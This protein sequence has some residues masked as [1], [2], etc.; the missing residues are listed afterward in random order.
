M[1]I[2]SHRRV[3]IHRTFMLSSEHVAH[4]N[5]SRKK[6]GTGPKTLAKTL[7]NWSA[8][9][10][11][12]H[13]M[14]CLARH[15]ERRAK[16]CFEAV[17]AKEP[18]VGAMLALG[19]LL[20]RSDSLEDLK[21]ALCYAQRAHSLAD[22]YRKPEAK[23]LLLES[24]KLVAEN[25]LSLADDPIGGWEKALP[26]LNRIKKLDRDLHTFKYGQAL[27]TLGYLYH[28]RG[29]Q[30]HSYQDLVHAQDYFRQAKALSSSRTLDSWLAEIDDELM[31]L[32][33]A[34]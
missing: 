5:Q 33:H 18:H 14:N 21:Q 16:Y 23:A 25:T 20:L 8:P 10:I 6:Q 27:V 34:Q 31:Q 7:V 28:E 11:Y 13:G 24:Y 2:Q 29:S 3:Q 30:D 26:Y 19:H 22:S 12:E 1:T 4:L 17:L 32:A 15:Q 9:K